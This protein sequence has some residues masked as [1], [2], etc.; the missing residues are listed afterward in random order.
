MNVLVRGPLDT[1]SGYGN[2]V[3]GM[4]RGFLALGVRTYVLPSHVTPPIPRDVAELL[5]REPEPPIDLTVIHMPPGEMDVPPGVRYMSERVIGWTMHEWTEYKFKGKTKVK[6]VF[7]NLDMLLLYDT[8]S[9]LALSS[10]VKKDV[11]VSVLQGGY[12]SDD[13]PYVPRDFFNGPF[14]FG[15]LGRLSERKGP[16]VAVEAFSKLK[17]EH[18]D[19]FDAELH[20]KTTV[21]GLHSQIERSYPGVRVH[22]AYWPQAEVLRFYSSL[23]CYVAPSRGEGKNVPALEAMTTGLPVIATNYGGH[24]AWLSNE[25]AY[26]LKY[27]MVDTELGAWADPDVDHLKELMWHVYTQREEARRKGE[28]AA[29]TIPALSDWTNVCRRALEQ[30]QRVPRRQVPILPS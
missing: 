12:W 21:P 26:P 23:H 7:S 25:Y 15:M 2:D 16:F 4:I 9:Y 10:F 18:G 20:L 27:S 3:V 28:L 8:V 1:T 11:P 5:T 17:A 19:A 30:V 29:R 22:Y 13:W 6:K 14:R 24:A